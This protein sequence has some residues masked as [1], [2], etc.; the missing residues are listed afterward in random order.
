MTGTLY[1]A[2][3]GSL[4]K[5]GLCLNGQARWSQKEEILVEGMKTLMQI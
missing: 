2:V 5:R 3:G 4:C 1:H